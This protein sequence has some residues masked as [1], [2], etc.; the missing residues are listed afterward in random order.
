LLYGVL[1]TIGRKCFIAPKRLGFY[2][3]L[4]FYRQCS[5]AMMLRGQSKVAAGALPIECVE[6]SRGGLARHLLYGV[7]ITIGRKCFIAPNS[8]LRRW[9]RAQ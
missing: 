5:G 7:L 3:R 8:L 6:L 9:L 4:G 1:I 2:Q